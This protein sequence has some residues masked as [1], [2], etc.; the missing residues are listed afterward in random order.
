MK[1]D[2]N[3][4]ARWASTLR[5]GGYFG[6]NQSFPLT[7]SGNGWVEGSKARIFSIEVFRKEYQGIKPRRSARMCGSHGMDAAVLEAVNGMAGAGNTKGVL[8][9]N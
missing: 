9:D 1:K 7:P 6:I 8:Y 3:T 5:S 4:C 2:Q